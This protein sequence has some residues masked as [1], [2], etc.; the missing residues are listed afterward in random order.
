MGRRRG[1]G[2]REKKVSWDSGEGKKEGALNASNRGVKKCKK[3]KKKRKKGNKKQNHEDIQRG[4][5]VF[6]SHR[7]V[8]TESKTEQRASNLS[9]FHP[10]AKPVK[11]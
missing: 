9:A 4:K 11:Y 1:G 5:Y 6:N 8:R 3:R 2:K 10:T 7:A